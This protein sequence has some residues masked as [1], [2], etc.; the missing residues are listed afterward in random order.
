[1]LGY[2][3]IRTLR[4][5]VVYVSSQG[6]GR[7]GPLGDAPAGGPLEAALAGG[8]RRS[9]DAEAAAPGG[10]ASDPPDPRAGRAAA[11]RLAPALEH[12]RRTGE[13]QH[14]ELAQTEAT[15]Y[16]LGE[17]Y[18]EAVATGR[19]VAQLGNAAPHACP[20]GVYPCAGRDRWCAIAVVGDAA[21]ERFIGAVG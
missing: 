1:W 16:L 15:A 19:P 14:I 9:A 5:A 13:G 20:H 7:A 10:S 11:A 3:D 6:V 2:D 4:P 21:W 8:A 18:L 17:F 12:R